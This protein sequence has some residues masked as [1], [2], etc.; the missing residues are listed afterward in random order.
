MSY[1]TEFCSWLYKKR[2]HTSCKFQFE[3]TSH[4]K[5]IAKQPLTN[6]YEMNS[7]WDGLRCIWT[8][9]LNDPA[10]FNQ[11]LW[12]Q[13]LSVSPVNL[14]PNL[15]IYYTVIAELWVRWSYGYKLWRVVNVQSKRYKYLY[16]NDFSVQLSSNR[17]TEIEMYYMYVL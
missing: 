4:K 11:C 10:Y 13:I 6:L 15:V 3:K 16:M 2:W 8:G 7:S 1:P 17:F 14:I 12:Y 9:A 5:V